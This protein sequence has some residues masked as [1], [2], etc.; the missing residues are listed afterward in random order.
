MEYFISILPLLCFIIAFCSLL[1][2]SW[3]DLKIWILP[4]PLVL[5]VALSGLFFHILT[6]AQ[7]IPPVDIFLG[8]VAGFGILFSIRALANYLYQQD[9]LGLGD[10][11]LMAAGGI[12]LGLEGILF[13]LTA[14]SI[15]SLLHGV[16]HYIYLSFKGKK[17]E[18][19]SKLQIPAGPGFA[20]G[21]ILV[22]FWVF[23]DFRIF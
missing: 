20:A 11:K 23:K 4:N 1:A 8:C 3:V 5:I 15:A 21:L 14:G 7:F 17:P 18:S 16:G 12:W 9:T 22:A 6:E 10:V 19:L 2:M 13:A